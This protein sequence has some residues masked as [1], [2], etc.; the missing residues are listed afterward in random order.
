M[1][2][3]KW[4]LRKNQEKK[5]GAR[6]GKNNATSKLEKSLGR[7]LQQNDGEREVNFRDN[8]GTRG[9]KTTVRGEFEK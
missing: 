8:D 5:K 6:L 2:D 9:E 3:E 7:L 4:V 1:K